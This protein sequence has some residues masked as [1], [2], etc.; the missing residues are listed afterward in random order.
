MTTRTADEMQLTLARLAG[1]FGVDI[2]PA[3]GLA[4]AALASW[5]ELMED[6]VFQ[7]ELAEL[8]RQ[9]EEGAK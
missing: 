6:E 1:E 7:R 5:L 9:R 4:G 3:Q 2:A 8:Q